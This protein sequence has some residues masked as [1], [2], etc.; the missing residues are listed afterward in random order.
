[1]EIVRECMLLL[2]LLKKGNAF[3]LQSSSEFF[4]LLDIVLHS[5]LYFGRGSSNHIFEF[6]FNKL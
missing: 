4:M 6:K 5:E 2:K 3:I 1:M